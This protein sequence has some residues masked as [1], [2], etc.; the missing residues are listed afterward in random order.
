MP[1]SPWTYENG[2]LNPNLEPHN[3]ARPARRRHIGRPVSSV[4]PYHPD[5][6]PPGEDDA[7]P[8]PAGGSSS[9]DEYLLP[10]GP[11]KLVRRGSEGY[12]V[13][14]INREAMLKQHVEQQLTEPGRYKVYVPEPITPSESESEEEEEVPLAQ[15][16][17]AWRAQSTHDKVA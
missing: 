14:T 4:P 2:S 1:E 10:S 3:P 8:D 15:K 16:V 7:F 17:E 5:Y 11:R 6:K 9:E 13:R 12:E